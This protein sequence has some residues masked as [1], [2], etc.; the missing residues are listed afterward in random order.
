MTKAR[1]C[2]CLTNTNKNLNSSFDAMHLFDPYNQLVGCPD[3]FF[4]S[5]HNYHRM[6][7]VMLGYRQLSSHAEVARDFRQLFVFASHDTNMAEDTYINL[8]DEQGSIYVFLQAE[9]RVVGLLVSQLHQSLELHLWLLWYHRPDGNG[10]CCS[11]DGHQSQWW[12]GKGICTPY[13]IT[14]A[15]RGE[16]LPTEERGAHLRRRE[17]AHRKENEKLC[18]FELPINKL[19]GAN[20][21]ELGE[22]RDRRHHE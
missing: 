11:P 15:S 8:L 12:S 9:E 6:S 13:E 1:R 14:E 16:K 20:R 3:P 7:V 17:D 5:L 18:G 22:T 10:A 2:E 19:P 4:N 21:G